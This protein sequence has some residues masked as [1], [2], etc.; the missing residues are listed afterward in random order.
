MSTSPTTPLP[1]A[2]ADPCSI[3]AIVTKERRRVQL[4]LRDASMLDGI[5]TGVP[6]EATGRW[7]R[8][9][10]TA[11]TRFIVRRLGITRRRSLWDGRAGGRSRRLSMQRELRGG[12]E[13]SGAK[14]EGALCRRRRRRAG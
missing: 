12:A 4:V 9:V 8:A 14:P 2:R 6:I 3:A 5:T 10:P 7:E 11:S 1:T 13:C